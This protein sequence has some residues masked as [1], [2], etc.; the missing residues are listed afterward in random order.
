VKTGSLKNLADSAETPASLKI[1]VAIPCFNE[2]PAIPTVIAQFRAAIPE[3]EIVVFDNNSTDGTGAIA[4]ATGA[5]VVPV[6]RQGKGHAVRAAFAELAAFDIVVLTDGD[7]TY[8]AQA[9]P[10]LIDLVRDGRADMSVGARHAVS[11]AGA[12]SLTRGLGNVLIR[13]AFWVLI[14]PG[15]TDLLSGYRAFNR[16]YRESVRLQSAGFEI[17]TELASEA[18]ARGLSVVEVPVAY[19]PRIAGTQSKLH[20]L[21]D[22]WRILLTIVRQSVRL[23]LPRALLV[24]LVGLGLGGAIFEPRLAA[25]AGVGLVGLGIVAVRDGRTKKRQAAKVG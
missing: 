7:G 20:A 14:G 5:R 21:R 4:R 16:H 13:A 8:P 23:R 25:V 12:M 11:G 15:T 22:G 10:L 2:G 1:A 9:A 17:E 24:L 3:A 6:P 18:V 19:H